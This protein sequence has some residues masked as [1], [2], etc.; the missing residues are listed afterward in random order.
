[1]A[2]DGKAVAT[3][4]KATAVILLLI[5]DSEAPLIMFQPEDDLVNRFITEV[6]VPSLRNAK[7][8]RQFLFTTHNAN[9]PVLGDAELILGLS[10]SEEGDSECAEIRSDHVGSVDN[11]SVRELV[12]EILEGGKNAFETRRLKYG[13]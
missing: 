3:G 10:A 12:S 13:F 4:Q 11:A 5:L 9:I 1:M 6:I 2:A 8:K 7:C